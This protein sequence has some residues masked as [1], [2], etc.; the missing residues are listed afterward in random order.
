MKTLKKANKNTLKIFEYLKKSGCDKD[1]QI[2][3]FEQISWA[4]KM[5]S[6][7]TVFHINYLINNGYIHKLQDTHNE[8]RINK[9]YILKELN[10]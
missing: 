7:N 2:I 9:Y 10:L 1:Y 8:H 3:T 6:R 5:E 4:I